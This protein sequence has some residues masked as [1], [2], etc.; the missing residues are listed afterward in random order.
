MEK[1]FASLACPCGSGLSLQA[2]CGRWHAGV[3]APS[4][5][6]LMRSRYSAYALGLEDYLLATWH[7]E[8][9]PS[10]L[11]LGDGPPV[12]WLGLQV[13]EASENADGGSVHFVARYKARGRP[14]FIDEKSRFKRVDGRWLYVDGVMG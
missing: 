7:P 6:A 2:C 8:T 5:E 3:P 14:G 12:R 9:R 4:A 11:N 1:H 13:L 10:A